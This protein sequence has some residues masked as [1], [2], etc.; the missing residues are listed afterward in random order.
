MSRKGTYAYAETPGLQ[1]LELPYAGGDLSMIV[2]LPWKTDGIGA[3]ENEL[4][5]AHLAGWTKA[6]R[7][8]DIGVALPK[9][10]LTCNFSLKE[11]LTAMGMAGAFSEGRADLSGMDGQKNWLYISDLVHKS[12]VDVNEQGTEAAAATGVMTSVGAPPYFRADHPFVFLIRDNH[13][14]SI[15]FLGRVINPTA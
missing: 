1:V 7:E 8:T 14:G 9:F 3:L 13:N 4:T 11:T 2:L 6:L 10:K 15:L 5:A 12:F